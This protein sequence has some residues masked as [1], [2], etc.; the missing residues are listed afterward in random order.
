[1]TRYVWLGVLLDSEEMEAVV[2]AYTTKSALAYTI[3][4]SIF[5][6]LSA[7]P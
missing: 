3:Y 1:M 6:I 5:V 2:F 7:F 4:Y